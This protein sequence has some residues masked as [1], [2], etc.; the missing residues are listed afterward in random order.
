MTDGTFRGRI[1]PLNL[2]EILKFLK[3]SGKSGLLR[4][5]SEGE[6]R[7]LYVRRGRIIA[8][9]S[10]IDEE[11]LLSMLRT[12]RKIS[13][14]QFIPCEALVNGGV[15]PGRALVERGDLQPAELVEWTERRCRAVTEGMLRWQSGNFTFE[16][17]QL[18]PVEWILVD[19]DILEALLDA[20]REIDDEALMASRLPEKTA[21]FEHFTYSDGG[22][23]PPLLA[24]ETYVLSL[25]NGR[26]DAG[27][28]EKLSELGESA[29]RKILGIMFLIGCVR[30]RRDETVE[31]AP[32]PNETSGSDVRAVI[33]A[34]NEMFGFLYEYMIKEVGPIAEH[35]LDKYLREVKD[36]NEA[37]F[38][39]ITLNKEG[40]FDE[41][42]LARN[43][44]L[45]RGRNR[46]E[47]L[48]KGLNEFLYS[49]QLA[50]KRT[51]G[52]EHEAIVVRR[53]NE[54]RKTPAPLG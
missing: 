8:V 15:R 33:R 7:G 21:V 9:E 12:E 13:E 5:E 30:H 46:L 26:R 44:H 53:L 17:R 6:E 4:T 49:G 47:V 16:E 29:T 11:S 23:A 19:L 3:E 20:L 38:N 37:L 32:V 34:Y 25:V 14:E 54:I 42:A 45:I 10:S 24:H 31:G 22:E 28:I 40:T 35:V 52:A 36:A 43:L 1:K 39:K 18:P 41:E 51:L 48:I 50:V 27:E 2:T